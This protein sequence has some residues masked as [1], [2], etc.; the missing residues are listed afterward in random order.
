MS[1]KSNPKP[2]NHN[3]NN[4][5][6]VMKT[7][8]PTNVIINN[9]SDRVLEDTPARAT[10][11]LM[12]A[13]TSAPIQTALAEVGFTQTD[14][15]E[16]WALVRAVPTILKVVPL[17]NAQAQA[18]NELDAWRGPTFAKARSALTR[19]HPHLIDFVFADVVESGGP[20]SAPL[21]VGKFL[22]HLNALENDPSRKHT[23][24]ADHAALATLAGRLITK[25]VRARMA[26][27]VTIAEEAAAPTTVDTTSPEVRKNAL[28]ALHAWLTD[29]SECAKAVISRRDIL[30][31][32]GI[33]KRRSRKQAAHT[34]PVIA[35]PPAQSQQPAAP[36]VTM[37]N[38]AGA[39]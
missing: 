26:V 12:A 34:P 22:A 27:L 33:G 11:F 19:L 3:H 4:E 8:K 5:G 23:R 37:Q 38:V 7:N 10:R 17:P 16:G 30:I 29:W 1:T 24:A 28:I 2:I 31:R 21:A 9:T 15:D 20:F 25:E 18:M 39:H 36:V 13:G 6:S 14:H 35:Q 32:L